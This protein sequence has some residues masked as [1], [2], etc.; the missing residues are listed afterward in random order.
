MGKGAFVGNSGMAAPGRKVPKQALVAVLSALPGAGRPRRELVAG[1]PAPSRC[2][3]RPS[4]PTRPAPTRRRPGCGSPERSWRAPGS[5]PCG[6][7]S[8]S[9]W[10]S[11]PPW[12]ALL[13]AGPGW[14]VVLGGPVL[15]AA[16]A[17]AVTVTTVAKW[18]L[19]GR[20]RPSEHPLWSSFVWRNELADTFVEVLAAPW[21]ARAATG[22]AVL[23]VWLRSMGRQ[24]RARRV[25]RDV[26]AARGRPHRPARRGHRRAGL[27]GADPPLPRPGAR[28]WT[29]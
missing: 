7:T 5:S 6:S 16:G 15:L 20:L 24:G 22:T 28:R 25:V 18:V 9:S 27:R 1:Q 8:A 13:D 29:G 12:L 17:V 21:F 19:V 23:N 14:A 10:S 2:A 11:L 4:W 3:A 26:L